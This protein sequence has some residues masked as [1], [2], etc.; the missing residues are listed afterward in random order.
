MER[1]WLQRRTGSGSGERGQLVHLPWVPETAAQTPGNQGESSRTA[2][3][4]Q[5]LP[6]CSELTVSLNSREI[7]CLQM[8]VQE[9]SAVT[10][11]LHL[12]IWELA[13]RLVKAQ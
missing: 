3:V 8:G 5:N 9:L 11:M 1:S 12:L 2:G 4:G 7:N 10:E 13:C 6:T